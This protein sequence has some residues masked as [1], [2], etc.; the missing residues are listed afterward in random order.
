ML[1]I[2]VP[3]GLLSQRSPSHEKSL[4][5]NDLSTMIFGN[6]FTNN[7]VSV[8]RCRRRFR[9]LE[10]II[11][12]VGRSP[13]V[14]SSLGSSP[15]C[16]LVS[17]RYIP[18]SS[19]V[20]I[21]VDE[22]AAELGR[23]RAYLS[24]PGT[25]NFCQ[26]Q[27]TTDKCSKHSQLCNSSLRNRTV[28]E[29]QEADTRPGAAQRWQTKTSTCALGQPWELIFRQTNVTLISGHG[30]STPRIQRCS[31]D[32]RSTISPFRGTERAA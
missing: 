3:P 9:L 14:Q 2:L 5:T 13:E 16:E 32:A 19:E 23:W 1:L 26:K 10:E 31:D 29:T 25:Q 18:S 15:R 4:I 7:S 12:T 11:D 6:P 21:G 27:S 17:L 30:L 24:T 28:S 22:E 8:D 20:A